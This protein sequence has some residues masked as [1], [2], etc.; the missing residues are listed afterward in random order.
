MK[1]CY[2]Q[3]DNGAKSFSLV[4]KDKI[5]TSVKKVIFSATLLLIN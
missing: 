5:I 1:S 4:D 3:N 2:V